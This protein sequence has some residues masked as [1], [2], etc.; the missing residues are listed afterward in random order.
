MKWKLLNALLKLEC[1]VIK[2]TNKKSNFFRK[3]IIDKAQ[4]ITNELYPE[5][6]FGDNI[7]ISIGA[8]HNLVLKKEINNNDKHIDEIKN[9]IIKLKENT[10][11]N[12]LIVDYFL[13]QS[14]AFSLG[15]ISKAV[16]FTTAQEYEQEYYS[17]ALEFDPN[18]KKYN[19][20]IF[21]KKLKEVKKYQQVLISDL[22]LVLKEKVEAEKKAIIDPIELSVAHI[23]L[24][25]SLFSSLFIVS[26][27]YYNHQVYQYF[28]V[29]SDDFYVISDYL[30]TSVSLILTPLF[31]SL[32]M[33]VA[34][35][36]GANRGV[37][38][39][40]KNKQLGIKT[41]SKPPYTIA[42]FIILL[43]VLHIYALLI[44]RQGLEGASSKIMLLN[45]VV[46][47]LYFLDKL[48]WQ[49]FKNP[50]K[51]LFGLVAILGFSLNIHKLT[52]AQIELHDTGDYKPA[53]IVEFSKK[54]LSDKPFEFI[55]LNSN[56]VFM[57]NMNTNK[58]EIY[59]KTLVVKITPTNVKSKKEVLLYDFL[60]NIINFFRGI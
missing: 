40:L 36:F 27:Y 3:V 15:K 4:I 5:N 43:N 31:W 45:Y 12:S 46:V 10:E 11:I 37:G 8:V 50:V 54:E 24:F 17:K 2:Y 41:E 47:G 42:L 35:M 34:Y 20:S 19:E 38:L 60:F 23:T 7:D 22:K 32:I 9:V 33:T 55:N 49:Y 25:A 51:V 29:N 18:A 39:L 57:K 26:G 53:Y 30:S 21:K 52:Q 14:Y 59:P 44:Q 48:P 16:K 1:W 13:A 56:Y 6:T 58:L 28:G